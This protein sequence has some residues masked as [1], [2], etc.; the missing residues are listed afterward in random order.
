MEFSGS[1]WGF[2]VSPGDLLYKDDSDSKRLLDSLN[3]KIYLIK[4]NH[5]KATLKYETRFSWIKDFYILNHEGECFVLMHYAM[6]RW[7]KSHYG[8][9]HLFGHSHSAVPDFPLGM[10]SFDVGVDAVAKRMS[11]LRKP[12]DY[13][14]I[15]MNEVKKIFQSKIV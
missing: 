10:R 5:E 9:N 15:S 7:Y 6:F 12:E 1:S 11:K 3:G 14:P 4:G 2:G 13:R 8:S